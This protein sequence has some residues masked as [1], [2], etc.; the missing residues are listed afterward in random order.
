MTDG[1][2]SS[3]STDVDD[4]GFSPQKKNQKKNSKKIKKKII[5]FFWGGG[6][7]VGVVYNNTN[8]FDG[9]PQEI[10]SSGAIMTEGLVF[11]GKT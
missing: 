2:N 10:P 8:R 1:Q 9:L 11:S 7:W 6:G 4:R 5:I 3:S